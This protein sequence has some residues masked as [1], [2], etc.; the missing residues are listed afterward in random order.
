VGSGP[1]FAQSPPSRLG[2][3]VLMDSGAVNR[4]AMYENSVTFYFPESIGL[5]DDAE[6]KLWGRIDA[7][8]KSFCGDLARELSR[9]Y[10]VTITA[11]IGP[12]VD[13]RPSAG[14]RS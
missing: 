3:G 13:P 5:Q 12:D 1:P 7:R 14:G 10:L 4:I 8:L 11:S 6:D 9:E 2:K